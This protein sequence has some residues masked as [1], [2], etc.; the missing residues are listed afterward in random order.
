MRS[1]WQSNDA[2]VKGGTYYPLAFKKY[3]R[4]QEIALQSNFPCT[5]LADSGGANLP[6]KNEAFPD[7]NHFGRISF[8]QDNMSAACIPQITCVMCSCTAGEAYVP[9]MSD[10]TA[11]V[12]NQATIFLA[13][14]PLMKAATGENVSDE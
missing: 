4:A 10:E 12:R 8:N 7:H 9:T 1:L 6:N 5:Y 3:L 13:R 14:M 11:M 2:T